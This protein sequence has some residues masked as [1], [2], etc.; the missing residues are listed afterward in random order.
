VK[1]DFKKRNGIYK[2]FVCDTIIEEKNLCYWRNPVVFC[3]PGCS[4]KAHQQNYK[5]K[6]DGDD[7]KLFRT[8]H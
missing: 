6:Q 3:G 5:E 7:L 4:L 8:T 1:S 2:C